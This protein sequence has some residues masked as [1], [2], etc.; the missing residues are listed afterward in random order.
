MEPEPDQNHITDSVDKMSQ[1]SP[2]CRILGCC[3]LS[4][5]FRN[6]VLTVFSK[7]ALSSHVFVVRLGFLQFSWFPFPVKHRDSPQNNPNIS[8]EF[9]PENKAR[10]DAIMANYP[11]THKSAAI[12]PALDLAQRQNGEKI[13]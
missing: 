6:S 11:P 4:S 10:L 2:S 13:Y 8:F 5:H 9:T 1:I 7:K 3:V 12:I